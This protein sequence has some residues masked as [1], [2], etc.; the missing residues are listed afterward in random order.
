MS[1]KVQKPINFGRGMIFITNPCDKLLSIHG[2]YVSRF[3]Q[4]SC[5]EGHHMIIVCNH[6]NG[7][8]DDICG[9]VFDVSTREQWHYFIYAHYNR[10]HKRPITKWI[11]F[12]LYFFFQF[13]FLN[14][15]FRRF[16][17][18]MLLHKLESCCYI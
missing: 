9:R 17:Q 2:D 6:R 3:P 4:C 7:D 16:K 12:S 13:F 14:N 18:K 1:I 8:G 5:P 10:V 15:N 11:S